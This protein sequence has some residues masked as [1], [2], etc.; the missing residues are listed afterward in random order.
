MSNF[1]FI[2]SRI[3]HE[4]YQ[5]VMTQWPLVPNSPATPGT[6]RNTFPGQGATSAFTNTTLE[7]WDQ[8]DKNE[9][10]FPLVTRNQCFSIRPRPKRVL[11]DCAKRKSQ[12]QAALAK[13]LRPIAF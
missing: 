4:G 3:L 7:T 9:D 6:I 12:D 10:R 2:L 13:Y 8:S 5:L 1:A 11:I